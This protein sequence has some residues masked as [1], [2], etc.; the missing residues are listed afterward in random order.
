MTLVR[1]VWLVGVAALVLVVNVVV[2]IL[3]MVVYSHLIDPG[4]EEQ[5]YHDHIQ[6]AAPY[7]SIVAGIPLMFLAGW[8]VGGWWEAEF[9][10]KAG[11]TI[12]LAYVLIDIAVLLAAGMTGSVAVLFAVSF[13]TKLAAV[14]FGAL[15]GGRRA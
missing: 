8:L 1:L 14:Y 10:I 6:V 9:A 4:H 5:Y 11:L 7:C 12:W 3:Y 2:S 15:V 13:A